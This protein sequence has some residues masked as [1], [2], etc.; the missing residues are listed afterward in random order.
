MRQ[1]R[2][3]ITKKAIRNGKI[4]NR[5]YDIKEF[6]YKDATWEGNTYKILGVSEYTGLKDKNGKE[7]YE[8]DIIKFHQFTQELGTNLGVCEGE[9]EF[10]AVVG[11]DC[12]GITINDEPLFMYNG[13]HEE[14][15]EIL[16]NIHQNPELLE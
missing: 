1:I 3:R 5:Y 14:S 13:V 10:N 9:K 2:F 8:E 11:F 16:G 7:I 12:A 6:N 15:I 4:F